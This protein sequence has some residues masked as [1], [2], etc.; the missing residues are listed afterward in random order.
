M[1]DTFIL[2]IFIYILKLWNMFGKAL[3]FDNYRINE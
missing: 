2:H 3:R 1:F